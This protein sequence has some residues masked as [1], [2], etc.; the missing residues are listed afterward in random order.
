MVTARIPL[1]DAFRRL[2]RGFAHTCAFAHRGRCVVRCEGRRATTRMVS[3]LHPRLL[4]RSS[5]LITRF[6]QTAAAMTAGPSRSLRVALAALLAALAMTVAAAPAH[7]ALTATGPVNPATGFPDWYEDGTGVKLQ[8]CLDGPPFCLTA[9]ADLVAPAGEGFYWNAQS[10][11]AIG[12]GSAKLVLA[13]EAA[14][15]PDR[16]TFSRIRIVVKGAR[17]NTAYTFTHQ[18][19][20]VPVMTDGLGNGRFRQDF[21]RAAAPC[22]WTVAATASPFTN[23]LRFN[24]AVAPA[25]PSGF[26]GDGV[27]PHVV[28]GG[29]AR[30]SFGF[31]GGGLSG[32]T[33]LFI[34]AGKVAGLPVPVFEAPASESWGAVAPGASVVQNV[35][36]TSFGVADAG[37]A[38][39]LAFGNIAI[40]GPNASEFTIVGNNCSGRVLPSGSNCAL[41]IRFAP[42]AGGLRSAELDIQ[43]NAVNGGA[44]ILLNGTGAVPGAGVAGASAS[45]LA[46]RKLRT[47]HRMSRARVARNGLRLSMVVPQGTEI[48]K[49]SV[50]R[51]RNNKVVRKP[52]WLGFRVAPSRAG[53]YRLTLDSR[54][55]RRRMKVGLYVIKVTPGASKQQLGAT[56]TTRIRITR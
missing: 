1:F 34:V 44:R 55:L 23:F 16:I 45:R 10:D 47:T 18:V 19:R 26:V 38:S 36:I 40:A 31:S 12:G 50:N 2:S 37:G 9:A 3:N 15:A 5:L 8:P 41:N 11:L 53:L 39:N 6:P 49:V 30:N 17:A 46:I 7:A 52:V 51:I 42:T 20:I 35:P 21:G 48:I 56:T 54:T 22:D 4:G 13:Q 14:F 24:P 32:A 43:H 33:N 28:I 25:A 27:T 29:T